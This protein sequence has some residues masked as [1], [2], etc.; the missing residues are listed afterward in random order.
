MAAPGVAGTMATG[1]GSRSTAVTGT[2]LGRDRARSRRARRR[3]ANAGSGSTGITGARRRSNG[4]GIA[5]LLSRV[6]GVG[7]A[8]GRAGAYQQPFRGADAAVEQLGDLRDGKV[9]EIA[10]RERGAV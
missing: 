3:A 10:Q 9:V 1:S 8:E 7:P 5:R 6:P 4:S 2:P